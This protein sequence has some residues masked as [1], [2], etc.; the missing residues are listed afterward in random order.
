MYLKKKTQ[1]N[2][3]QRI[4]FKTDVWFL[5]KEIGVKYP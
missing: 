4:G 2:L 3:N 1:L 5:E